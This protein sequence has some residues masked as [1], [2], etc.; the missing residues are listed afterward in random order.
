MSGPETT[1]PG[2]RVVD[3]TG[4]IA[5][6]MATMI[7]ADLGA[8]VVKLEWPGR[9]DDARQFPP[10]WH[11]DSTV[12]LAFNRNKRSVAVDLTRPA[13]QAAVWRLVEGADVVVESFRPGKL[14]K[15]GWSYEA[16]HTRNRGAIY[17]S[18]NAFGQGPLGHDLPGFDPVVQAFSG[19]M[20]ATGHP[21]AEPARVPVSLVDL[22]TGMWAALA[23]MAALA[24]RA[25]TGE[26]ERLETTL[27]DSGLTL[28]GNQIL[29]MLATGYPPEPTG[30]AFAIAAPYEA[31]RTADGWMMIAAGNDAIF[32]RLCGA[33]GLD[34]V[35]ADPRF[36][37]MSQRVS[38]RHEL[39]KLIEE[40]TSRHIDA[41]LDEVLS[42]AQVPSSPV[43]R[44]DRT[45][46][47]P[48][49]AERRVMIGPAGEEAGKERPLVRLP[50]QPPDAVARRAPGVGEHTRE[51]LR[52]AGLGDD[53]ID[54]VISG[55]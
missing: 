34:E 26:G 42:S 18:V 35:A 46:A 50:F 38:R 7:L 19:I 53:E 29:S 20:A 54:A 24:R 25:V 28:V 14:D 27:V 1:Y 37:T 10:F 32:R 41:D 13:G 45:L 3:F 6:P 47:H 33:L 4:M 22:T 43:N 39:H 40:R 51:V 23:I 2:L 9:G 16:V 8:D 30:S 31:F 49:T 15:L 11:G 12:F 44:L 5:G 55:R 48:L 21:G 36:T 17:C 52:E